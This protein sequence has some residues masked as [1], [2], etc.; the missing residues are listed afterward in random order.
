[1]P[2]LPKY[3]ALC[4]YSQAPLA[5]GSLPTPSVHPVREHTALLHANRSPVCV[6][7]GGYLIQV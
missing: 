3:L 5:W 4:F 7:R 2:T 1:M 6:W